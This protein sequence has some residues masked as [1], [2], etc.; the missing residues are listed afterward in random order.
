MRLGGRRCRSVVRQG[1]IGALDY[2]TYREGV[3]ASL[4]AEAE[5]GR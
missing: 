1:L 4:Q 5:A 3:K 2:P